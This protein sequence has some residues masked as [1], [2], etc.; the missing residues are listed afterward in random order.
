M[1]P[2]NLN[3]SIPL[4]QNLLLTQTQ[5]QHIKVSKL[6]A[7]S[8]S[9]SA[10]ATPSPII[11]VITSSTHWWWPCT[12]IITTHPASPYTNTS[13]NTWQLQALSYTCDDT[14]CYSR[15]GLYKELKVQLND[16][17]AAKT[18]KQNCDN[19]KFICYLCSRISKFVNAKFPK[20]K[21]DPPQVK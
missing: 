9:I 1:I 19:W 18:N 15:K 10:L 14:L 21:R 4:W 12:T 3:R 8:T 11:V 16:I 5:P 17:L 13:M 20:C 2:S 6:P 7:T